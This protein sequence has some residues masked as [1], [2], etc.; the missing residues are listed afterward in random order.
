MMNTLPYQANI[1]A[2]MNIGAEQEVPAHAEFYETV[3]AYWIAWFAPMAAVLP[4]NLPADEPCDWVEGADS[5]AELVSLI[6][7]GDYEQ[8]LADDAHEMCCACGC[9]HE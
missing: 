5:L 3:N 4:P 8:L 9:H 2:R 6:E 7:S 1:A